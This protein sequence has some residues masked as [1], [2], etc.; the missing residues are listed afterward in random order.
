MTVVRTE[1]SKLGTNVLSLGVVQV[2]NY[3]MPLATVPIVSRIIGPE[4]FGV[5]NF[6][7]AF[8]VYLS[9]LVNYG[10]SLTATRRLAANPSDPENRNRIFSE[11]FTAQAILL[12]IAT[13]IFLVCLL[14][15]PQ[16][17]EE[18]LVSVFTF[19]SCVGTLFTQEWLFQAMQD[20]S[21]VAI[22]NF[23]SKLIFV[24]SILLIINVQSDYI[25]Y[26]LAL[27]TSQVL[28][29]I[30]SFV[31]SFKKY[32]IKLYIIDL[33]SS[34]KLLWK[35][36]TYFTSLI[37][38][39]LYTTANIVLLGFMTDAAQ[40]GYYTAGTKITFIIQTIL[41]LPFRHTFFPYISNEI[42]K[43][44]DKGLQIAQKL[45]PI[46][47]WPTFILCLSTFFLSKNIILILFGDAFEPSTIVLRILSFL[48]MIIALSNIWGILVMLNLNFD[49]IYFRITTL[50][51]VLSVLL[52]FWLIPIWSYAGTA[53]VLLLTQLLGLILIFLYLQ[54]MKIKLINPSYFSPLAI[55]K[56]LIAHFNR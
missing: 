42:T 2:A 14:S 15:I 45:L 40:V 3:L 52:N 16:L 31:W 54:K 55:R 44:I 8:V 19:F 20:L 21:K 56:I 37:V 41:I 25:W 33:P 43:D 39:N 28:V 34:L 18:W 26:A 50:C 17:R 46:V 11:V 53:M 51:A 10:F 6:A 23:L 29:G 49:K 35:E 22:L 1:S 48:P 13:V 4:K 32:N 36:K 5:I 24:V 12:L 38:I 9:L 7:A 30:F 47:L 27:S